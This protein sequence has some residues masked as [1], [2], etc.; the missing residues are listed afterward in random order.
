MA[1]T[2]ID[3]LA[4]GLALTGPVPAILQSDRSSAAAGYLLPITEPIYDDPLED[5]FHGFFQAI[6]A[7]PGDHVRP[8]WQPEPGNMP[9]FNADWLAFGITLYKDDIFA[10]QGADPGNEEQD[11]IE[12][13]EIITMLIS[14][15]GPN[16]TRLVKLISIGVQLA[17]NRAV[18]RA[19]QITVVEVQDPV[20]LPALL[21]SK[22]VK[23]TDLNIRFRRRAGWTYAVRPVAS[24]DL[25]LDN[26]LYLTPIIVEPNP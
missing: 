14:T 1:D 20:P 13:D 19:N 5:F 26:E 9:D 17:Q 4:G 22:W 7:L 2:P 8:R 10:Y 25:G 15:Y 3:P 16:A 24:A 23:R 18:L 11:I 21:K 6:T 12:R